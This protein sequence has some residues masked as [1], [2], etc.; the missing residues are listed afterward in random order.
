MKPI[1]LALA[2]A[3]AVAG[4]SS[5]RV[6]TDH[7]PKADFGR[8]HTWAWMQRQVTDDPLAG[9]ALV[10]KRIEDAIAEQLAAKGFVPADGGGPDFL[11]GFETAARDRFDVWTWPSWHHPGFGRGRYWSG[12]GWHDVEVTQY[13]EGT[14]IVGMTDPATN[15]LV[16]RGT[17]TAVVT[18][19]SGS[20]KAIRAAVAKLLA[21]FPPDAK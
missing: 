3:L 1:Q 15:D 5:V 13:T 20:D 2:I 11:V 18:D 21:G 10:R 17:A 16:W 12:G 4:C 7:D 6:A 9:N 14:L 8:M 19:K